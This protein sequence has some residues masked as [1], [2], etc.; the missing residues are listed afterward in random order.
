[1]T[2]DDNDHLMNWPRKAARSWGKNDE[3]EW[4]IQSSGGD[5]FPEK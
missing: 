3:R 4:A 2:M 5:G 1:M